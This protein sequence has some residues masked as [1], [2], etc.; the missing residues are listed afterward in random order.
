[1]NIFDRPLGRRG[2]LTASALTAGAVVLPGALLSAQDAAA[3][4]ETATLP[5]RGLYDTVPASS[6]TDGFLSGNGEFGAVFHGSPALEKVVLNHHRFVLPNGTRTVEPPNIASRLGQVQDLALAGDYTGASN[7]FASGWSLKW[8]QTYHP[9]YELHLSSPGLATPTDYVRTTNFRTGE[10]THAWS[11]DSG[12]WQ[13]RAFVSRGSQTIVHE[14]QASAQGTINTVISANTA[15]EAVPGN[16][17]YGITTSVS[18]RNGYLEVRGTYPA[19]L[20]AYGFEGATRV[21]ITGAGSSITTDGSTLTVN[22]ATRVILLT[23]LARYEG[24]NDWNGRPL[25]AALSVLLTDYGALLRRHVPGHQALFDG[26]TLDLGVSVQDRALSTSALTS[27]QAANRSTIDLALLE[28]MYDSGRYLF[29]SSSGVLPPRLTGIWTG[30]WDG[31]WAD[32]FTTDA[33]INLQVAGGNIL[34]SGA[35]DGYFELILGQLDD[36][37]TNARNIYGARGFLAPTRTDGEYGHMLH[38]NSSDFPGEC[39]TGGAD[40]LLF[41]LLEYYQVTGDQKFYKDKLGPA[42]MELALFY[43]DFLTRTDAAG[44]SVFVPSYSMENSPSSTGQMLSINATA[45]IMAGRHAL[46]AAVDAAKTLNVEQGAGQGVARWTA[47]LAKLPDYTINSDGA[48]AEWSWPGL[49]DRYNHRHVSHLYGAWPLH[50][51]NPEERPDLTFTARKALIMRGDENYSA[52][53]SLH[54][55]LASARLKDGAGVY[56][57]IKKILGNNMV[58]RSLITSHNPE[59]TTYNADAAHAL[60]AVIAEALTYSRPGFLEL[61]PALPEQLSKGTI[62]GV[63]GRNRVLVE[64]LT[65]DIAGQSAVATIVSDI[66]QDITLACRRGITSI[67]AAAATVAASPLG[68]HARTVHLTAGVHVELQIGL[69]PAICQLVNRQSGKVMDVESQ[70]T[71]DGAAVI[72]WSPAGGTNQQWKL[73]SGYDGSF[74]LS[75]VKSGKVLDN[76]GTSMTDGKPLDQWTDNFSP[77]QWWRLVPAATSGYYRLVN[78]ASGLCLDVTGSVATDGARLVQKT[79]S[80]SSASQEWKLGAI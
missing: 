79:L 24:A 26:S 28:R 25:H 76:P 55:A 35:M 43:E 17:T 64:S 62:T 27:R 71:N 68:D 60:P 31:A 5:E 39:W 2:F 75:S 77:N 36:W 74:R 22:K 80:T 33:N 32:D 8:T 48:L 16:V 37:R 3:L 54:R 50:E 58:W 11:D 78:V 47:L 13:R 23:K 21:V 49:T 18:G 70:S 19:G 30:S 56:T 57:N 44:R 42:L 9:G 38:F 51:I 45:D 52:H 59:L 61:L 63:R 72:Q 10:V 41:P 53:G 4:P 15:L 67:T 65:W 7:A 46:Q 40:W 34:T 1:M 6:W 29:A 14:L 69:L 66:T 20:G 12:T 73:F